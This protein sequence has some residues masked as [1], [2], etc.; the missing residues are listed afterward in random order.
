MGRNG[1]GKSTLLNAIVG[2][3][4]ATAGTVTTQGAD[5]RALKGTELLA[6]VG[7]VPQT[8]GDLLEATSVAAECRAADRDAKVDPGTTRELLSSLASEIG[9]DTHPRDLSEG[10]RLLLA[11]AIVLA[12]QPPVLLLDEPTRGLDYPTK[13]RLVDVLRNL[14]Q[15]G[16]AIILATHDVELAAE[17][18]TRVV[19][20]A[21]GEVVADGETA[22]VVVASPMF[23]PQIAKILAPYPWLT[24]SDVV[25][26]IGPVILRSHAPTSGEAFT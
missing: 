20:L 8:P 11:L 22:A 3:R 18:A 4:A 24:V 17:V 25:N 19:V 10:Q 9:D 2:L 15:A 14:A 16:H 21:D 23:A 12:A 7:L 6:R 13:I 5:P 1:A 26:S